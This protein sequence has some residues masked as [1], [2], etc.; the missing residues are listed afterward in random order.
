V[1]K[2]TQTIDL[3]CAVPDCIVL[4]LLSM[5][6]I[7]QNSQSVSYRVVIDCLNEACHIVVIDIDLIKS[8]FWI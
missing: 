7:S 2:P 8:T 5:T 3:F 1:L 4:R 6:V